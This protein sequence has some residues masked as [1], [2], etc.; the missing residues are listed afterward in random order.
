MFSRYASIDGV[1]FSTWRHIFKMAAMTSFH[2][3][4]YCHLGNKYEASAARAP[5]RTSCTLSRLAWNSN[6]VLHHW[7]RLVFAGGIR[8]NRRLRWSRYRPC[9]TDDKDWIKACLSPPLLLRWQQMR[10]AEYYTIEVYTHD[11]RYKNRR[12]KSTS[13]SG[14]GFWYVCHANPGPDLSGRLY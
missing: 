4:N 14:A 5:M 3:E 2:A 9:S 11:T 8:H 12:H 1:G 6:D 10:N 13:F 7:H